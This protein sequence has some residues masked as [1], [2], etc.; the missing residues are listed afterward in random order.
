MP[1]QN[2][3]PPARQHIDCVDRDHLPKL[4]DRAAQARELVSNPGSTFPESKA[5]RRTS[6][7]QSF[8][9]PRPQS[10]AGA[11][12][13][14]RRTKRCLA[15]AEWTRLPFVGCKAC[16]RQGRS[17]IR[18]IRQPAKFLAIS[19]R[20]PGEAKASFWRDHLLSAINVQAS[21]SGSKQMF[22]R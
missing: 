16:T 6:E 4:P 11:A 17:A 15:L 14:P 5:G 22:L 19:A 1:R 12:S 20:C 18:E 2:L 3:G 9:A 10:C 21:R 13:M 7:L 8:A